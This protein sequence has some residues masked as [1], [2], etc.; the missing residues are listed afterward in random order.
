MSQP[1]DD[2]WE[3]RKD[4]LLY[5][6]LAT[7]SDSCDI[8][9]LTPE[10]PFYQV[11]NGRPVCAEEC[12]DI[13]AENYP[14]VGNPD[15]L[16]LG[17]ELLAVPRP[18]PRR[19]PDKHERAFDARE[20]YLRERELPFADQSITSLLTGLKAELLRVGRPLDAPDVDRLLGIREE[21]EN[22][23]VDFELIVRHGFAPTMISAVLR[24]IDTDGTDGDGGPWREILETVGI[25]GIVAWIFSANI[26]DLLHLRLEHSSDD[27]ASATVPRRDRDATWLVDRFTVTYMQHWMPSSWAEERRYLHM[28]RKGCC[29]ASVM[30]ERHVDETEVNKYLAEV[31]MEHLD[32]KA[33]SSTDSSDTISIDEMAPIALQAIA[34]GRRDDAV[35]VYR[36]MEIVR[37]NDSSVINNLA[38]CLLPDKPVEALRLFEKAIGLPDVD[39][40][41]MT[42]LNLALARF[43]CGDSTGATQELE[44]ARNL[45]EPNAVAFMWDVDAAFDGTWETKRVVKLRTYAEDL[46]RF[47]KSVYTYVPQAAEAGGNE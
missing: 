27:L 24:L 32:D 29:A 43:L 33:K 42:R 14:V 7:L 4:R 2:Q 1:D 10:C 12:R 15:G 39:Y 13:L 21:L 11:R 35:S 38:F 19:G 44:E 46:E 34:R 22:H 36:A 18:K 28:E 6:S 16:S 31:A 37:P 26:D 20:V 5:L 41:M 17:P 47:F 40:P 45:S 23:G 8:P 25:H 30:H 9:L 3:V